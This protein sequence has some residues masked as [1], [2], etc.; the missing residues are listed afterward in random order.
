MGREE[1]GARRAGGEGEAMRHREPAVVFAAVLEVLVA[2]GLGV[3]L[4]QAIFGG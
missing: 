4:G 2:I 1:E 3:L